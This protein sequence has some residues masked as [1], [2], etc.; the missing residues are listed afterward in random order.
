LGG[1]K[2]RVF[3]EFVEERQGL[4]PFRPKAGAGMCDLSPGSADKI[5]DNGVLQSCRLR[6]IP[7]LLKYGW[8]WK[9]CYHEIELS[10]PDLLR[11]GR[12]RSMRLSLALACST[13]ILSEKLPVV[14]QVLRSWP[15]LD[16]CAIPSQNPA[17]CVFTV[18]LAPLRLVS[19]TPPVG[20]FLVAGFPLPQRQREKK[21]SC[22]Q[23][24]GLGCLHFFFGV[25]PGLR[26]CR[27]IVV[28]LISMLMMSHCPIP[29]PVASLLCNF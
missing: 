17:D 24:M 11:P 12:P 14:Y 20:Q 9:I 21:K 16:D 29:D 1:G 13:P 18:S 28:G 23:K 7:R 15:L 5:S 26:G 22:A 25:S 10:I 6:R 27:L 4:A 19:A 8:S 2:T 3:E